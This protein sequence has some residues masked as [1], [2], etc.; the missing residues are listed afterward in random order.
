MIL[1]IGLGIKD[2]WFVL[3]N[4]FVCIY[5]LFD[6]ILVSLTPSISI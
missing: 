5:A 1:L 6:F 4:L 3:L 2:Y